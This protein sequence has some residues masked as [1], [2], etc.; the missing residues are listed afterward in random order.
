MHP[1]CITEI[2]AAIGRAPSQREL[3]EIEGGLL[4]HM[5]ELARTEPKW[6]EMSGAQRLQAAAETAQRAALETAEK[7]AER[8]A[9]NLLAQARETQRLGTRAATL[10]AQGRAD[11][12]HAALF[13]RM[14]TID[15][16]VSGV[17][18]ESLSGLMDAID[19][20]S[21]RFLGLMDDPKAVRAFARAVMDGKAADPVFT[22]A[23]KT[24]T[25]AMEALRLR[26]NAA[27]ADIG[28]LDYGYLPQPHDVGRVARAG[29]DEWARAVLPRLARERYTD[30]DGAVMGDEAVIDL[31]RNAWESIATEGRNQRVPG[32]VRRGSRAS[33]FD[34]AHRAI[35]FKDA[36]SY[37]DYLAEFGRGSMMSAIHAHVGQMARTIGLMEEFGA[38]P[39]STFRL[40]KD[41]AEKADNVQGV[42][43]S[44]ATLDMVWDTLNG[45]N[46]Q[47]VSAKRAQFFQGVRNF[48]VAAK[49]QGVMLS[50]ITD[51]PLQV[52]VAKSAGVPV[53]KEGIPSLFAGVGKDKKRIAHE[54]ALGVDEI[55]G[56]MARW[57]QDHLAQGWTHKLANTTMRL[58]LVQAWTD[59]LRRGY[60]LTLSGTLERQRRTAWDELHAGDKIRLEAAGVTAQDWKVW[61]LAEATAVDG[62]ALLTKDGI[63]AIP[64][65]ALEA[66]GLTS[67]DVNRA[68]ARLLGYLDQEARTAVLSPDIMT[69]AMVQQGT[70]AGTWGGESLRCLMLFKSFAFGIIDKHLRRLRNIPTAQGKAAYSVAMMTSLTLFGAISV[71]LKDLARGKDP[72]DMTTGKFWMAAFLQGGGVGILGDVLYTGMGGNARGGQANWTN[73]LGP[74]FGQAAD[75][76]DLTLGNLYRAAQGKE[77]DFADDA[78]RAVR[79]NAPFINL[80]YLRAAVDHLVMHDMQEAVSP[81]YLRRMRKRSRREWGQEYWWEPGEAAPERLPSAEA[82]VGE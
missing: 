68:T 72:R 73:L 35:H 21:P 36:D 15:D 61:Q 2:A 67:R 76:A 18:N 19:A 5:R 32:Q 23:A 29:A 30:A 12:H 50:S 16:Y 17:R 54:L 11:A 79:Y 10:A 63:R 8:R 74:V 45:T 3:A 43:G 14:R 13:E 25:E 62:A 77:T 22:Q 40:L 64:A 75:V 82:A 46:A 38:N 60:S 59:A 51:A 56:E 53:F 20:V 7:T 48:T 69:R 70:R 9:S 65:A 80:W 55:A 49:L 39:T 42:T 24:Y 4:S 58:T 57:H 37:L 41:T 1:D 6:R 47:P 26:A 33:R 28:K 52:I 31:L 81:G 34:D 78:L 27:G 66:A 71:Q 44:L